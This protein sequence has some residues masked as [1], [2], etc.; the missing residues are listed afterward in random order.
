MK[1]DVDM[2]SG[3]MTYIPSFIQISSG[4]QRVI[5]MGDSERD[6]MVFS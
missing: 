1:Y 6:S 5:R 3:A 2:S 4:V